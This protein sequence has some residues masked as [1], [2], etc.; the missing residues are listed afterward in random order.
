MLYHKRTFLT[1]FFCLLLPEDALCIDDLHIREG[2]CLENAKGWASRRHRRL[3]WLT[4]AV[5]FGSGW[6]WHFLA[7]EAA[8]VPI[9][10][11]WVSIVFCHDTRH[12]L[13]L[14]VLH[15]IDPA[16]T[17]LANVTRGLIWVNT[18]VGLGLC[19][20]QIVWF[21]LDRLVHYG[22][23][24]F[25]FYLLAPLHWLLRKL[26]LLLPKDYVCRLGL[27]GVVEYCL[28]RW[29]LPLILLLDFMV[30]I[31]HALIEFN[32]STVAKGAIVGWGSTCV[33]LRWAIFVK[34][35]ANT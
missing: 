32:I 12:G 1:L 17:W 4:S 20:S 3:L 22:D 14:C 34:D 2:S 18:S 15:D 13:V 35:S 27:C 10:T 33:A 5:G 11:Q 7:G 8:R 21:L 24:S 25:R 31:L 29:Y 26:L 23:A 28:A 16:S 19:W 30:V 9:L 6:R